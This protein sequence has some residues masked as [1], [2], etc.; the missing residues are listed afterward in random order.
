M[1]TIR[2]YRDKAKELRKTA[3]ETIDAGLQRALLDLAQNYEHLAASAESASLIGPNS[4]TAKV[5]G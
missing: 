1:S 2:T 4:R 5:T 3:A